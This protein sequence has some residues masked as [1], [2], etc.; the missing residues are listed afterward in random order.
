MTYPLEEKKESPFP[1][2]THHE[3]AL[4]PDLSSSPY[5]VDQQIDQKF[6]DKDD[7]NNQVKSHMDQL[8]PLQAAWAFKKITLIAFLAAFAAMMDGYQST[9]LYTRKSS[10]VIYVFYYSR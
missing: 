6:H 4:S 5:H 1:P 3:S 7:E 8:T 10:I 2:P 9:S